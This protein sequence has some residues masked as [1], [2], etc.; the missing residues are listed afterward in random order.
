[1]NAVIAN[2]LT[3]FGIGDIIISEEFKNMSN[4]ILKDLSRRS[5]TA[6]YQGTDIAVDKP[7]TAANIEGIIAN[8]KKMG[9][10]TSTSNYDGLVVYAFAV[11]QLAQYAKTKAQQVVR[12]TYS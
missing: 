12:S 6:A 8:L 5:L 3:Y 11:Q 1:M 2:L 10:T 9:Y 4:L 7:I